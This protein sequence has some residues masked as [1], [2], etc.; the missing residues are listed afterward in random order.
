MPPSEAGGGPERAAL[1]ARSVL[2]ALAA[3]AGEARAALRAAERVRALDDRTVAAALGSLAPFAA[4]A[5]AAIPGGRERTDAPHAPGQGVSPARPATPGATA[6]GAAAASAPRAPASGRADAAFVSGRRAAGG[7][8]R[9]ASAVDPAPA[10]AA[11]ARSAPAAATAARGTARDLPA[12]GDRAAAGLARNTGAFA[13]APLAALARR[14]L[15]PERAGVEPPAG[16]PPAGFAWEPAP[17]V[18][19]GGPPSTPAP[20]HSADGGRAGAAPARP[21]RMAGGPPI[22][23]AQPRRSASGPVAVP[24][25]AGGDHRDGEHLDRAGRR[26]F[27]SVDPLPPETRALLER[28]LDGTAPRAA[29]AMLGIPRGRAAIAPRAPAGAPGGTPGLPP[30]VDRGALTVPGG[31]AARLARADAAAFDG[32]PRLPAAAREWREPGE[33]GSAARLASEASAFD[34]RAL[35]EIVPFAG[36]TIARALDDGRDPPRTLAALVNEALVEQARLHGVD[37]T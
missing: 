35:E 9:R 13:P 21:S 37:L 36:D 32:S 12:A 4:L 29:V 27:R 22:T 16:E 19:R 3:P 17:R 31:A 10:P 18:A 14:A 5:A 1:R 24:A 20:A 7:A 34:F 2:H 26:A 15:A 28:L 25:T 8:V 6:H 11:P 33:Y 23:T 30:D